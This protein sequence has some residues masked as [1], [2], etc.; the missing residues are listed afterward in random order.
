MARFH[1]PTKKQETALKHLAGN[2][3]AGLA[4]TIP[5]TISALRGQCRCIAPFRGCV[6][7][8]AATI[9]ERFDANAKP[10]SLSQADQLCAVLTDQ[11]RKIV[12]EHAGKSEVTE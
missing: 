4:L 9:I 8:I 12:Y 5:E 11:L 10:L 6:M 3:D 1:W 2:A 7:C